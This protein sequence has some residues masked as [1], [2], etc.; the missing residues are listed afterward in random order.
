MS[1]NQMKVTDF[2]A[3]LIIFIQLEGPPLLKKL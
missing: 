1:D 2:T 3:M